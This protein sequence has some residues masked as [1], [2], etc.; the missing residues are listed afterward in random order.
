[1]AGHDV[2]RRRRSVAKNKALRW[3]FA[4]AIL[5]SGIISSFYSAKWLQGVFE[6]PSLVIISSASDLVVLAITLPLLIVY[7]YVVPK[8]FRVDHNELGQMLRGE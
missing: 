7:L 8:I 5:L 2:M 4:L 1:M 6:L 3:L